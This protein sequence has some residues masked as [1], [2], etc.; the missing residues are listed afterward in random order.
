MGDLTLQA[1]R[2]LR[3]D[4]DRAGFSLDGIRPVYRLDARSRA[5]RTRFVPEGVDTG[6]EDDAALA[7]DGDGLAH[8]RSGRDDVV[9][10]HDVPVGDVDV[11]RRNFDLGAGVSGLLEVVRLTAAVGVPDGLRGRSLPRRARENWIDEIGRERIGEPSGRVDRG[12]RRL[13]E[14]TDRSLV[15]LTVSTRSVPV[16]IARATA[17]AET[18]SPDSNASSC[19]PYPMYGRIVTTSSTSASRTASCKSN[20][21]RWASLET[22]EA[23]T[24]ARVR[25]SISGTVANSSPSGKRSYSTGASGSSSSRASAAESDCDADPLTIILESTARGV[26]RVS[27]LSRSLGRSVPG[28]FGSFTP[29]SEATRR[30]AC[31]IANAEDVLAPAVRFDVV[32]RGEER[33]VLGDGVD[34]LAVVDGDDP[35]VGRD[36]VPLLAVERVDG[37]GRDGVRAPRVCRRTVGRHGDRLERS[38]DLRHPAVSEPEEAGRGRDERC[39]GFVDVAC[40]GQPGV[41]EFAVV[42]AVDAAGGRDEVAV[43]RLDRRVEFV[44]QIRPRAVCT[45]ASDPSLGVGG[46][47]RRPVGAD[48]DRRTEPGVDELSVGAAGTVCSGF[49]LEDADVLVGRDRDRVGVAATSRVSQRSQR[50]NSPTVSPATRT[51][52][53][54]IELA[55]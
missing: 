17:R 33:S 27:V 44:C 22:V 7:E 15:G 51:R 25:P 6:D 39:P 28:G 46:Q 38:L 19:R 4:R 55:T 23:T 36:F 41:C 10:D 8:R 24:I 43:D 40:V 53:T 47:Q 1:C 34:R 31:D 30:R 37:V 2:Q 52:T 13:E 35:T 26:K 49:T 29:T 20:N 18:G 14:L 21:S 5:S 12:C 9:G 48:G 11:A 45:P 50:P 3:C 16:E 32:R 54:P 42:D